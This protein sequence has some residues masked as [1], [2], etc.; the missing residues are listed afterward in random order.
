MF[1]LI[2]FSIERVQKKIVCNRILAKP[3]T[4]EPQRTERMERHRD[5]EI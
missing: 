5:E 1:R 4:N 2:W 3:N